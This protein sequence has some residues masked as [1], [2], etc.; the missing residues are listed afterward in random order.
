MHPKNDVS[1][2]EEIASPKGVRPHLVILG[3][4]LAGLMVIVG[5]AVALRDAARDLHR[6]RLEPLQ[7]A[8]GERRDHLRLASGAG[9]SRDLQVLSHSGHSPAEVLDLNDLR[10]LAW[11]VRA[12]VQ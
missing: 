4:V 6:P 11:M 7:A 1:A 8:G 2:A 5:A 12:L 9:W 10:S 3:A